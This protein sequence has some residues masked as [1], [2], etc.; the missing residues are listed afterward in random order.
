[1]SLPENVIYILSPNKME[2]T[3]KVH[4]VVMRGI[5]GQLFHHLAEPRAVLTPLP[6]FLFYS[7]SPF[8]LFPFA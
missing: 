4:V 3:K 1:V 6:T 2:R 8:T 5:G 7:L